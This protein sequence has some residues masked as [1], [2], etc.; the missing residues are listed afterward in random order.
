M[1]NLNKHLPVVFKDAHATHAQ[2]YATEDT[3]ANHIRE[4]AVFTII[5][6][7]VNGV[8]TR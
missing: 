1:R 4:R 2:A 8:L 7:P 6:W 5:L 3:A